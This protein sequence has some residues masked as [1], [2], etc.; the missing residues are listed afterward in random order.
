MMA[1]LTTTATPTTSQRR[2]WYVVQLDRVSEQPPM[3]TYLH[4]TL[5]TSN[6][7]SLLV[8]ETYTVSPS[9]PHLSVEEFRKQAVSIFKEYFEHGDTHD[10]SVS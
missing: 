4:F 8:Q 2:K 3:C 1:T 6:S 9:R 7:V 10:V 5:I